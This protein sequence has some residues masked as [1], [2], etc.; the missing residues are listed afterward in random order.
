MR[1]LPLLI[2]LLLVHAA[3]LLPY[4]TARQEPADLVFVSAEEHNYLDPQKISWMHD[5]RLAE[6]LYEPLLRVKLPE[7]TLEPAAAESYEV[8]AD[9]LTYTFHLRPE[10]RWSNGEPVTA[11]DFVFAWRRALMPDLAADYTELLFRIAGAEAFFN[12]RG[13]QLKAYASAPGPSRP[14]PADPQA[15]FA[16]TVGL[17]TPDEHTLVVHLAK[18]CTY[19]LNLCAFATFLPVHARSVAASEFV[20]PQTG[21]VTGDSTYWSD[22]QRLVTNGPYVLTR[23]RFKQ[24]VLLEQNL[25]Y[26][27]RAAMRNRSIRER[28]IA[29]PQTAM[30]I[31][32]NGQADWLPDI[33]SASALAADLLGQRRP[34]VTAV[35]WVGTYFYNF[36]CMARLPDGTKNPLAD[37]RVRRALSMGIDRQAIVQ[38]VTRINQPVARTFVPPGTLTGYDAPVDA[39]V[40]FDPPAARELL[41]QAGY[42]DGKSLAGLSILYNTNA[43][44][45][46]IAQQIKRS[47]EE[48]LGVVVTLESL[49]G[50]SFSERLKSHQFTI[51]R[52]NWIGDYP[53]PTTF[54]DKFR[55]SNGNNDAA[56][57][58]P[59]FDALLEQA[60]GEL[61]PARRMALLRRAEALMLTDQP[62]APIFHFVTINVYDPR[63]VKNL[64][65]NSWNFR[66]LELV[67]VER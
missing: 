27:N 65:P 3:L 32:N 20:D 61:D 66:R 34:D 23:R 58:N 31:Y 33:P 12:W 64:Y 41:A 60:E 45:A 67:E 30:M 14:P 10:A 16:K 11:G 51:T 40:S 47:W 63:K 2:L 17:Q 24:D 8:S 22:P 42:A 54:L 59:A 48:H 21:L 43:G 53:D 35:P 6:C 28:I 7:L 36:N 19:F 4:R 62:I 49:E 25:Y 38:H 37:P 50:K 52:A 29:D 57:A 39:G 46:A 13:Q 15:Y 26:W 44:H 1:W 55:S 18:P 9:G 56:Y 5:I